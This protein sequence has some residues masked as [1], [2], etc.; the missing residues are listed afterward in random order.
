M[1]GNIKCFIIITRPIS[2]NLTNFLK[3]NYRELITTLH[4]RKVP[5]YLIS[6]G[7]RSL[8]L[9]AAK[10]LSIPP[11]NV[12]ANRLKFYFDG[13]YA[14]FDEEQ[15]TSR[16][17]GKGIVIEKL[18]KQY[19]YQRLVLIGDGATD[20]EACPPADAFIDIKFLNPKYI[21]FS[22]DANFAQTKDYGFGGNVI[23]PKVQKEAHWFV[24]SF[25][26]LTQA[27][28]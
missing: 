17:G 27:L 16:S 21:F 4:Q 5:V 22:L 7:F 3:L 13:E 2:R 11:E 26:E 1:R 24:T 28:D 15:P 23:R 12:Y 9:P 10:E 8:I 14:G 19:G 25:S 6:G 18:K 20:L